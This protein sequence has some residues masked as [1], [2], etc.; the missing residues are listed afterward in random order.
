[1][2]SSEVISVCVYAYM[3]VH[4]YIY[5]YY[6]HPR[7]MVAFNKA[8]SHMSFAVKSVIITL[9][10]LIWAFEGKDAV[11]LFGLSEAMPGC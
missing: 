8:L 11:A 10:L 4:I 1:M 3:Y 6:T 9:I 7:I 5:I 2:S